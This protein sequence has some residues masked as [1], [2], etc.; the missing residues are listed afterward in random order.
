MP[1][2]ILPN[3]DKARLARVGLTGPDTPIPLKDACEA[4]FSGRI[5]VATLKAEQK[6]GNLEIY[7]IGRQYFTSFNQI[8]AMM[9]K[10]CLGSSPHN[11]NVNSPDNRTEAAKVHAAQVALRLRLEQLKAARKKNAEC[12]ARA[13]S[14]RKSGHE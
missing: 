2:T 3:D 8:K 4:Y 10:C 9:E 6:R 12:T 7:K 5:T 14:R 1:I 11:A 13:R